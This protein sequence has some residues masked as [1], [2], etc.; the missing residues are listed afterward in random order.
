VSELEG[1]VAP[2]GVAEPDAV[3]VV[4]GVRELEGVAEALEPRVT[5]A[6]GDTETDD[7]RLAVEEGV[8]DGVSVPVPVP[9]GVG[10]SLDDGIDTVLDADVVEEVEGLAPRVTEGVAD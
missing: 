7:E 1:V 10:V 2:V 4:D 6:E 9:L 3:L 5:D 8:C